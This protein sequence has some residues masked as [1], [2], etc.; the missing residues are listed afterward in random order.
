MNLTR[1]FLG[2]LVAGA[3]ANALDFVVNEFLLVEDMQRMAQRFGLSEAAG[4]GVAITWVVVDFVLG[5]LLVWTYASMRPR[6]GAGP[7]TA[8]YAALTLFAAITAIMV[9]FTRMGLFATPLFLK[10]SICS[11]VTM[12][13]ASLA[14]AWLYKEQL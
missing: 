4:P 10:A 12:C 14:G 7:K 5:I 6:F 11:L 9:G 1:V 8:I 13:V 2:G 3:I